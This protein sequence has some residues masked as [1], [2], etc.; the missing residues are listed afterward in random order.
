MV[1]GYLTP[2]HPAWQLREEMDRLLSGFFGDG[3]QPAARRGHPAVNVWETNE[4][5]WV[6]LEVPGLKGDELDV[7][8]V[9]NELSIKIERLD[10]H[11]DGVTYHRRERAVGAFA[12]VLRLPVEVDANRVT[13]EMKHGVLTIELPKAPSARP[14]KIQVIAAE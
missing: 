7:S 12:R 14:R 8:V 1:L 9:D 3:N 4:S 10:V 13:A 11:E 5:L 6:E 2:R